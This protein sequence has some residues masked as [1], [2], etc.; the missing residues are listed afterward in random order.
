MPAVDGSGNNR[1]NRLQIMLSKALEEGALPTVNHARRGIIAHPHVPI[2]V[3]ATSTAL[4][5]P[6]PGAPSKVGED[7][8]NVWLR[9]GPR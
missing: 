2:D 8:E 6:G 4:R 7:A 9:A 5:G 1:T 3:T